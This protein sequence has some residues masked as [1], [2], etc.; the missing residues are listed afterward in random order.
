MM[1]RRRLIGALFEPRCWRGAGRGLKGSGMA[2]LS[3]I[4]LGVMG[5]PMAG[6]LAAAGHDV[7]VYNRTGEKAALWASRYKGRIAA[8]PAEAADGADAVFT[9]VGADHDLEEVTL[10]PV[11][12]F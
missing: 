5:A 1:I 3:F 10:G 2:K 6:H 11:G 8:S 9:C 4:G 12:A 7:T